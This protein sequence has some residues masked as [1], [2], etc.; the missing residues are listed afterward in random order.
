MIMS[1]GPKYI[2]T[3]A[4]I[5]QE[6]GAPALKYNVPV[7][8]LLEAGIK[9]VYE[10]DADDLD[11]N[12][13][14]YLF[15]HLVTRKDLRGRM[16]SAEERIDRMTALRMGTRWA[17]EY[18]LR[19]KQLGSLEAGKWADLGVLDRDYASVPEDEIAQI[20]VLQT[21]VAGKTVF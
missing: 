21:L 10:T 11:K 13:A 16:W 19:E 20:K 1:C 17:S 7:R 12:G 6:Y 5:E 9:V 14:F 2:E 4:T 8:S 15:E 3:A 18:V